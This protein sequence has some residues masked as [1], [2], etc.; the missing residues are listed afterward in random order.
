MDDETGNVKHDEELALFLKGDDIQWKDDTFAVNFEDQTIR[1]DF[2]N[3]AKAAFKL[4]QIVRYI[5]SDANVFI[6]AAVPSSRL[7]IYTLQSLHNHL[8]F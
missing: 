3:D 6:M 8:C 2:V 7:L 4:D 5:T 1:L